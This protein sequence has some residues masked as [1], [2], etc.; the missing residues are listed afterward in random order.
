MKYPGKTE[1]LQRGIDLMHMFCGLN[2]IPVPAVDAQ[3]TR[4]PFAECAFYRPTKITTHP[5]MTPDN[6]PDNTHPATNETPQ[7]LAILIDDPASCFATVVYDEM[8]ARGKTC[9]CIIWLRPPTSKEME[10]LSACHEL[11]RTVKIG[12]MPAAINVTL[13]DVVRA[14]QVDFENRRQR[15]TALPLAVQADRIYIKDG[16]KPNVQVTRPP[17]SYVL[18]ELPDDER[19]PMREICLWLDRAIAVL[20]QQLQTV[21]AIIIL[22]SEEDPFR[23]DLSQHIPLWVNLPYSFVGH[24]EGLVKGSLYL[25]LGLACEAAP[26]MVQFHPGLYKQLRLTSDAVLTVRLM[27][28]PTGSALC[29]ESAGRITNS[30]TLRERVHVA[31][32]GKGGESTDVRPSPEQLLPAMSSEHQTDAPTGVFKHINVRRYIQPVKELETIG[33]TYLPGGATML[34]E[35]QIP[36]PIGKNF[37][38]GVKLNDTWFAVA[39]AATAERLEAQH[40]NDCGTASAESPSKVEVVN[41][42]EA[43]PTV[44]VP[45]STL[46]YADVEAALRKLQAFPGTQMSATAQ[47]LAMLLENWPRLDLGIKLGTGPNLNGDSWPAP[48]NEKPWQYVALGA[49]FRYGRWKFDWTRGTSASLAELN[50]LHYVLMASGTAVTCLCPPPSDEKWS[51]EVVG[52]ASLKQPADSEPQLIGVDWDG[53]SYSGSA[54][55]IAKAAEAH[56]VQEGLQAAKVVQPLDDADE[57]VVP[58]PTATGAPMEQTSSESQPENAWRK[59]IGSYELHGHK[60]S[61]YCVARE[62]AEAQKIMSSWNVGAGVDGE[63]CEAPASLVSMPGKKGFEHW[64]AHVAWLGI[65]SKQLTLDALGDVG[66]IHE[67][68][69]LHTGVSTV[70]S[71]SDILSL[72]ISLC[73]IL[74]LLTPKS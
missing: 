42:P 32:S 12:N 21:N 5:P 27:R 36:T 59:F 52:Y 61:C 40:N 72:Y 14:L 45:V 29:P 34:L 6:A 54:V 63:S 73:R 4:W 47:V 24:C 43:V 44:S 74:G 25:C 46:A 28:T 66:I 58:N 68:L 39:D 49:L 16:F 60:F 70:G 41:P 23:Q 15:F 18:L 51:T 53:A 26:H 30:K 50:G 10:S 17:C 48:L 57:T 9:S 35:T 64:L 37:Y 65:N 55:H 1:L 69:H 67:L 13:P 2:Q 19:P 31:H 62:W 7:P 22:G 8:Q 56:A 20:A 38:E 3:P 33:V 71:P 11:N